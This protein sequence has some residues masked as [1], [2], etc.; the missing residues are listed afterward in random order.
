MAA[1][2][3][4]GSDWSIGYRERYVIHGDKGGSGYG[5]CLGK[6]GYRVS[7]RGVNPRESNISTWGALE[8]LPVVKEVFLEWLRIVIARDRVSLHNRAESQRK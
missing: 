1:E 7:Q 8:G 2:T 5:S 3:S 4:I 6:A